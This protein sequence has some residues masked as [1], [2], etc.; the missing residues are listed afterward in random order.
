MRRMARALMA[1][2]LGLLVVGLVAEVLLWGAAAWHDREESVPHQ[3]AKLDPQNT[4]PSQ[5]VDSQK[6]ISHRDSEVIFVGNSHT[7]GAGLPISKSFPAQLDARWK[8][9]ESSWR[10]LN[11][12]RTNYNST[13]IREA[14][15][16]WLDET[17]ATLVVAMVGEPNLWNRVGKPSS[18]EPTQ[19][20]D[21]Q[22]DQESAHSENHGAGRSG[23]LGALQSRSRVL[24]FLSLLWL[25]HRD[26][27]A[28]AWRALGIVEP[29]YRGPGNFAP[30]EWGSLHLEDLRRA[31]TLRPQLSEL[32][33]CR[34]KTKLELLR[35]ELLADL[36]SS[37]V[38]TLARHENQLEQAYRHQHPQSDSSDRTKSGCGTQAAPHSEADAVAWLLTAERLWVKANRL[39]NPSPRG[40]E[41]SEAQDASGKASGGET[42]APTSRSKAWQSLSERIEADA[43]WNAVYQWMLRLGSLESLTRK[44]RLNLYQQALSVDP[45]H[46]L[47]TQ[48]ILQELIEDGSW[49]DFLKVLSDFQQANPL[50]VQFAPGHFRNLLRQK[51]PQSV[52]DDFDRAEAQLVSWRPEASALYVDFSEAEWRAWIERDLQ[53]ILAIVESKGA[54]LVLQGYPPYRSP[55]GARVCRVLDPWLKQFAESHRLQWIDTCQELEKAFA[56]KQKVASSRESFYL[57]QYGPHDD[58]LNERGYALLAEILEHELRPT[59][60]RIDASRKQD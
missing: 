23:V 51:A 16:T 60:E 2:S 8:M 55:S 29:N 42:A 57:T 19:Q 11:L 7:R 4:G 59:L 39:T 1:M 47:A 13:Q 33:L 37:H 25:R 58:H 28:R 56:T 26:S 24:N 27:E 44:Q 48:L 21:Q 30:Q 43:N 40:S 38:K 32:Q 15:P 52:V 3:R 54:Q 53:G 46:S 41:Q 6:V 12:G 31:Q 20:P 10:A 5:I 50:S 49:T 17:G 36:Q 18:Q 45:T 22:S 35:L 14:L 34:W 9:R